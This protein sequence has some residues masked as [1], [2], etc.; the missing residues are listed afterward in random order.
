MRRRQRH[1]LSEKPAGDGGWINGGFFVLDPE[2]LRLSSTATTPSWEREPLERLAAR[3]PAVGLPPPRLLAADGYAAR[4][5]SSRRHCGVGGAA[6]E[7]L[8]VH[9]AAS[10][11]GRA[12][13]HHRPHRVQGSWLRTVAARLG[14][15]VAGF[16]LDCRRRRS[17]T[18]ARIAPS[19][20]D[21][22]GD[23]GDSR[24]RSPRRSRGLKPEIVFHLAA[25]SLVRRVLQ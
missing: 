19:V 20:S 6:V 11:R 25:Q 23:I 5:E 24:C 10:W 14:A 21:M 4:Q 17:R 3:R 15:D 8:G 13:L 12:R 9:A 2:G 1:A 7:D 22:R 16:A 18:I